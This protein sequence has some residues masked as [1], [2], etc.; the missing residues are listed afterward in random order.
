[1][2]GMEEHH[3]CPEWG[4]KDPSVMLRSWDEEPH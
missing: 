3:Q 4:G 2:L 1:M